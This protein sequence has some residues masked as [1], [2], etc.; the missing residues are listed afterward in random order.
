MHISTKA[1][2]QCWQ[3]KGWGQSFHVTTLPS[4]LI[5]CVIISWKGYDFRGIDNTPLNLLNPSISINR[6]LV[7]NVVQD[8][9]LTFNNES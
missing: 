2:L 9:F 5:K 4:S 3:V 8:E 6:F 1:K 7:G